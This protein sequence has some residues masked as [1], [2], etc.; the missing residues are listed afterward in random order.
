MRDPAYIPLS[1]H[2]IVSGAFVTILRSVSGAHCGQRKGT[3]SKGGEERKGGEEFGGYW[4]PG[5]GGQSDLPDMGGKR[6]RVVARACL[7]RARYIHA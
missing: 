5:T 2:L 1:T 4:C 6:N 7:Q 3:P